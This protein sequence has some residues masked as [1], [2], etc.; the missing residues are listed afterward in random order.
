MSLE[1]VGYLTRVARVAYS[2]H[3]VA[4]VYR[5]WR[6]LAGDRG[7]AAVAD[8]L[9]LPLAGLALSLFLLSLPGASDAVAAACATACFP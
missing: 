4:R 6:R 5:A 1:T 7:D 8:V 9:F 2:R 3:P